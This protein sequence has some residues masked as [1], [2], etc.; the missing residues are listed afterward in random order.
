MQV[1]KQDSE[2]LLDTVAQN[3]NR[4]GSLTFGQLSDHFDWYDPERAWVKIT[5]LALSEYAYYDE[6]DT[7][8]W[9][10]VCDRLNLENTRGVQKC[11]RDILKRGFDQLNVVK[12][13]KTIAMFPLFG[14]RVAFHSKI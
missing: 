8:F 12:A 9:P 4:F 7:G 1:S 11:F 2:H 10:S 14:Y 13:S 5:T 6:S 3:M